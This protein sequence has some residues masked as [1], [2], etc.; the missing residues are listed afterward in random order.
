M[1]A[2]DDRGAERGGLNRSKDQVVGFTVTVPGLKRPPA[3]EAGFS[4]RPPL[5]FR[6][7]RRGLGDG[8]VL[9]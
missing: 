8:P 2:E 7:A 1:F 6:L 5:R 9:L 3:S 4:F